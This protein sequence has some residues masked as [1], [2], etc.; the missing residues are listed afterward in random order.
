MNTWQFPSHPNQKRAS[1]AERSD[2]PADLNGRPSSSTNNPQLSFFDYGGLLD[3]PNSGSQRE[4][5]NSSDQST[6]PIAQPEPTLPATGMA[7]FRRGSAAL[8]QDLGGFLTPYTSGG[9]GSKNAAKQKPKTTA[10]TQNNGSVEEYQPVRQQETTGSRE[11]SKSPPAYEESNS[12]GAP[13]GK[14]E[15]ELMDVGGLLGGPSGR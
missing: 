10:A 8:L 1:S 12:A 2:D 3:D 15:P 9:G 4:S 13:G 11:A 6:T 5:Y 14:A 7:S